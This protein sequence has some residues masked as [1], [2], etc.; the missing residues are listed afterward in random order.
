[1]ILPINSRQGA[2]LRSIS[3]LPKDYE[4]LEEWEMEMRVREE[5]DMDP[6]WREGSGLN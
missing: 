4:S 5:E 6:E 1:M 2:S 3:D